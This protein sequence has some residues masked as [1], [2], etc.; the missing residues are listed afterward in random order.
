MW[1]IKKKIPR[2]VVANKA[3]IWQ[4]L[5]SW[6]KYA[7]ESHQ[8][9]GDLIFRTRLG[10]GGLGSQIFWVGKR[11]SGFQGLCQRHTHFLQGKAFP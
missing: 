8:S 4:V 2:A 11:A 10:V 7:F 3:R 9:K 5:L 1:Q 6:S